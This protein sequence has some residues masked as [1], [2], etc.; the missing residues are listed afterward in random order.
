MLRW[1]HDWGTNIEHWEMLIGMGRQVPDGFHQR[2]EILPISFFHWNA[3]CDLETERA[4]GMA[5]GPI[6]RSKAREYARE[7]G[8]T[9]AD[10]LADFL[11]IMSRLDNE[12]TKARRPKDDEDVVDK[13]SAKDV[14]G[15]RSIMGNIKKKRSRG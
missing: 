2:P 5:V 13:A 1:N 15:V 10:E 12:S 7:N 11:S 8:I 3:F 9:D 14:K 6:P 4:Y